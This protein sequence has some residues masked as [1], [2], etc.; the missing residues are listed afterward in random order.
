MMNVAVICVP[1]AFAVTLLAVTPPPPPPPLTVT[2]CRLM[3]FV[4]VIVTITDVPRYPLVGLMLLMVGA[5]GADDG[6]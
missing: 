3:K 6:P 1:A 2:V 5:P 4:P